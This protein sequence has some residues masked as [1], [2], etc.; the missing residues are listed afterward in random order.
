MSSGVTARLSKKPELPR[1]MYLCRTP[2]A[3]LNRCIGRENMFYFLSTQS[4]NAEEDR[5][6]AYDYAGKSGMVIYEIDCGHN[7]FADK[8]DEIAEQTLKFLAGLSG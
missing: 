8:P 1:R 6:F 2:T 7:M 4:E 5:K 3:D